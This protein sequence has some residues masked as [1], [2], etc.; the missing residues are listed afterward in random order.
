M[1]NMEPTREAN[2]FLDKLSECLFALPVVL[3]SVTSRISASSFSNVRD[4]ASALAC[5]VHWVMAER[6][7]SDCTMC[8]K[9]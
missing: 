6:K 1:R 7:Y 9:A 4:V 5:S 3:V 8:G 2:Q